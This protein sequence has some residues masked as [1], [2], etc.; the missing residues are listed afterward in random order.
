MK[1][2]NLNYM[3]KY[4]VLVLS[5]ISSL[6][7]AQKECGSFFQN[8]EE[9]KNNL[10]QKVKTS[11]SKEKN[12]ASFENFY[13]VY[14]EQLLSFDQE[15]MKNCSYLD[16]QYNVTTTFKKLL[17]RCS[18]TLQSGEGSLYLSFSD[19]ALF[20]TFGDYLSDEYKQYLWISLSPQK[21]Y[22]DFAVVAPWSDLGK[23]VNIETEF[24][25]KFP[26]SKKLREVKKRYSYDLYF[27]LMGTDNTP[28]AKN[29]KAQNAIKQF[30]KEYPNS[31]ATNIVN[32]YL[33]NKSKMSSSKLG[34]YIN[35]EIAKQVGQ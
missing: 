16:D 10:L 14:S 35:K 24:I 31:M 25:H 29:V 23:L 30:A 26:N 13:Q 7:I 8:I 4:V 18:L 17:E 5:L 28:F 21:M 33:K 22:E 3:K 2:T 34:I 15:K 27:F 6:A 20:K 9:A 19:E 11:A 1:I 12:D 32:L